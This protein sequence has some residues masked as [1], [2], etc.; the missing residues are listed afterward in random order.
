MEKIKDSRTEVE[1]LGIGELQKQGSEWGI[2]Y[3]VRVNEKEGWCLEC[4]NF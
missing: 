1:L 4:M 2:W 3:N